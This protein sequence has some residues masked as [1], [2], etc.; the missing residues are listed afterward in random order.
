M[1]P[2]SGLNCFWNWTVL[3]YDHLLHLNAIGMAH[4]DEINARRIQM[5]MLQAVHIVE[6]EYLLPHQVKHADL[7]RLAQGEGEIAVRGV[8]VDG[9]GS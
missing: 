7:R 3:F 8:G 9:E 5:E 2:S 1:R 4:P 6:V